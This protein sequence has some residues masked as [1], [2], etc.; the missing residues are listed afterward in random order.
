MDFHYILNP[1]RKLCT[2]HFGI[3]RLTFY[4]KLASKFLIQEYYFIIIMYFD[5]IIIQYRNS[6][7]NFHPWSGH[8][9][10]N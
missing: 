6:P 5:Y 10:E 9:D 2:I 8:F 7:K 3:L 4:R 1:P